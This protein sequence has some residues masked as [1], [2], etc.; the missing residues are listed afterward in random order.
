MEDRRCREGG[1]EGEK[2]E[3]RCCQYTVGR[4]REARKI[5]LF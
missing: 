3:G 4:G 2:E 1:R 5:L